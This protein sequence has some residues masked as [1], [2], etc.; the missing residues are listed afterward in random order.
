MK[1]NGSLCMRKL[2]KDRLNLHLSVSLRLEL[3][4]RGMRLTQNSGWLK[5]S[6]QVL[7]QHA[8]STTASASSATSGSPGLPELAELTTQLRQ[9]LS[10]C[11]CK[12]LPLTCIL[13]DS[14]VRMWIVT[15]PQNISSL[16]DCQAAVALRFQSLYG[17]PMA[18][19]EMAA[20]YDARRP[21]LACAIPRALLQMLQQLA[22]ECG[23]SLQEVTPQFISGWNRHRAALAAGAWFGVV[24]EDGLSLGVI[25]GQRLRAVR[26]FAISADA[27]ADPGGLLQHVKREALRLNLPVPQQ[28]Q[29]CGAVP[30]AWLLNQN[31]APACIALDALDAADSAGRVLG[32]SP[33]IH[34]VPVAGA[35]QGKFP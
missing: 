12:N 15:P 21:F 30:Q 17:E 3:S 28:L 13:S 8:W 14:L 2:F 32:A 33:L 10:Q 25:D 24:N 19:W 5:K 35:A 34:V 23:L 20:D 9:M 1:S 4:A 22:Q 16:S 6:S 18:G 27:S 29:L 26:S 7:A 31:G 11:L